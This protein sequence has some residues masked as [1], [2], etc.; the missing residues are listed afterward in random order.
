MTKD[1]ILFKSPKTD[2]RGDGYRSV[3]TPLIEQD[4]FWSII[5]RM[6]DDPNIVR[7]N[8]HHYYLGEKTE[9]VPEQYRGFFG[10]KAEIRFHD[11]R[12]VWCVDVRYNGVIPLEYRDVLPDN[13]VLKFI[14]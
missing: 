11:G 6:R 4:R 12:Q 2:V 1:T 5:Y 3:E 14:N 8:G 9:L 13:A 10:R 7:S